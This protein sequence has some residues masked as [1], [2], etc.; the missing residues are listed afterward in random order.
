[1]QWF[2]DPLFPIAERDGLS[3]FIATCEIRKYFSSEFYLLRERRK[4]LRLLALILGARLRILYSESLRAHQ[5][6]VRILVFSPKNVE[7][8]FGAPTQP[9]FEIGILSQRGL[10]LTTNPVRSFA[11][12]NECGSSSAVCIYL[13]GVYRE[14]LLASLPRFLW[15]LRTNQI[16]QDSNE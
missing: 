9:P 8:G 6:G 5:S 16:H 1:M 7:I 11:F 13:R 15:N 2:Q 10:L 4:A 3:M 12:K 14:I